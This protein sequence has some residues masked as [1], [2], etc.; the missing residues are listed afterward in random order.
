MSLFKEATFSDDA[1]CCF[2]YFSVYSN[3][4]NFK[5]SLAS[6]VYFM[7]PI[8]IFWVGYIIKEESLQISKLNIWVYILLF[9]ELSFIFF[10]LFHCSGKHNGQLAHLQY[11]SSNKSRSQT[12]P[13]QEV[14]GFT[15]TLTKRIK[16][17][18]NKE[19][20]RSIWPKKFYSESESEVAQLCPTLRPRGL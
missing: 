15:V 12:S 14:L 9:W 18:Q 19:I 11:S 4:L 13:V 2:D 5:I 17:H 1:V 6:L 8:I 16:E 7:A 10:F 20:V 3:I